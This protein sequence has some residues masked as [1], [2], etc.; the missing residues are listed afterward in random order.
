MNLYLKVDC[1]QRREEGIKGRMGSNTNLT[2]LLLVNWCD[3]NE[4]LVFD[5]NVIHLGRINN[6]QQLI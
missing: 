4:Y 6:S 2:S 5:L 3:I 1:K